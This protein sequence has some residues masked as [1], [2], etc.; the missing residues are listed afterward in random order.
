MLYPKGSTTTTTEAPVGKNRTF[1]FTSSVPGLVVKISFVQLE[2][3]TLVL[4][5]SLQNNFNDQIYWSDLPILFLI[6]YLYRS[7]STV[8]FMF[9]K[10]L[11][12]KKVWFK[13]LRMKSDDKFDQ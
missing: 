11:T 12:T 8:F 7:N 10:D 13:I 5:M 3:N 9:K 4:S 6:R 1:E 2:G